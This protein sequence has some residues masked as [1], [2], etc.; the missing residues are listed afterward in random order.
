M[1]IHYQLWSS[2]S[3]GMCGE[4]VMIFIVLFSQE[5]FISNNIEFI[6][7]VYLHKFQLS[8]HFVIMC[9]V[10]ISLN[11]IQGFSIILLVNANVLLY[12]YPS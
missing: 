8:K 3:M 6:F 12:T 2:N 5:Y 10:F 9:L 11:T 1:S 7:I 4:N